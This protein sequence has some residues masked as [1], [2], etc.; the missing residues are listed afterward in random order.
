LE[1]IGINSE[2]FLKNVLIKNE[3]RMGA[4][5]ELRFPKMWMK[6]VSKFII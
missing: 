6:L 5:R 4:Y 3:L 2:T 1:Y